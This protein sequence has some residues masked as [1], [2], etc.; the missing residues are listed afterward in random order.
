ML[1]SMVAVTTCL[2]G[3]LLDGLPDLV[4]CGDM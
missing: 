4:I 1:Y 3:M 2:E